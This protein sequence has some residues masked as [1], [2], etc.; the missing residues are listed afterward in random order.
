ML[1]GRLSTTSD[2]SRIS[3]GKRSRVETVENIFTPNRWFVLF[4]GILILVWGALRI[5]A[6]IRLCEKAKVVGAEIFT[7]N[8]P[9]PSICTKVQ[10][11]KAQVMRR[12]SHD[13]VVTVTGRQAVYDL[14]TVKVDPEQGP[15][16]VKPTAENDLNAVLTFYKSED[17]WELGKVELK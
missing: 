6:D 9:D 13:A 7:F 5:V 4:C 17:R 2:F 11:I 15:D 8:W 1:V 3:R 10:S 12:S 16:A 14:M